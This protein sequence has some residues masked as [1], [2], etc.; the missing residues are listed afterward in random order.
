MKYAV[1]QANKFRKPLLVLFGLTTDFPEASQRH[2][3]FMLEGLKE[4]KEK[5]LKQRIKIVVK[6][7]S[8]DVDVIEIAKKAILTIVDRGYLR[9]QIKWRK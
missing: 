9:I 7:G 6:I 3:K 4:T 2:Y 5:F 8:P 1:F